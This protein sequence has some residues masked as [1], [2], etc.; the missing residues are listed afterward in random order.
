MSNEDNAV[1]LRL[2]KYMLSQGLRQIEM[3]RVLGVEYGYL[4]QIVRGRKRISSTVI[5]RLAE[6]YPDLNLNWLL[7]GT[8]AML[9]EAAV[10][11]EILAPPS[12]PDRVADLERRVNAL[13][14]NRVG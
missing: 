13:E 9:L 10:V 1:G 8:G 4:N 6:L 14:N 3:A 5:F 12:L 7:R 2:E 11:L